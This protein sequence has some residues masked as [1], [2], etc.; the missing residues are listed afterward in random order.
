M[1]NNK[2]AQEIVMFPDRN[3]ENN[4]TESYRIIEKNGIRYLDCLPE[5]AL[6]SSQDALDLVAACGEKGVDRLLLHEQNLSEDFY[7][8]RTGLAGEVLLKFSN[9]RILAAAVLPT[10]L[11]TATSVFEKWFSNLTAAGSSAFT[12]A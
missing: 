2:H 5:A 8:L 6:H 12:R 4:M 11:V 10:E 7:Q 3:K 1:R 9:Y